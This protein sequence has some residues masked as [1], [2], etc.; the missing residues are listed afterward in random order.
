MPMARH[1]TDLSVELLAGSFGSAAALQR[2]CWQSWLPIDNIN[3]AN[4]RAAA[5]PRG[6][7][8]SQSA[9]LNGS[10]EEA[11]VQCRGRVRARTAT[12]ACESVERR[13]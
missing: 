1:T 7:L 5:L 3:Y 9:A 10:K 6:R 12:N 13:V 2:H 4:G 11:R 8:A